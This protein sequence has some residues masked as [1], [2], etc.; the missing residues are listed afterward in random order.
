MR[1]RSIV[2]FIALTSI[3]ATAVQLPESGNTIGFEV[4]SVKPNDSGLPAMNLGRP[5]KGRTYTA[6]N[7]AL[8]NV[9]ALAYGFPV[10]RVL[11][12]PSWVGTASTDLRF[13]GGDRFDIAATLPQGV[14]V[15]Q[16]PSMLRALL[17]DRFRL[18][19]HTEVRQTPL[20]ALVVVRNDGRLGPQLRKAS[21]D[22]EDAQAA[23]TIITTAKAGERSLCESEVGSAILGRGQR[24]SSLGRM[25]S[26]FADR[27]V[28]D[29][30]GLAGGFDFE[31]RFPEL[32]TAP[33]ATG[34]RA[35]PVNGIFTALQEQ[36]GLK[37]ESTRGN[38]ELVVI[39]SVQHPTEN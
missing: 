2:V 21:I 6:T 8:R 37:L 9:I 34:P 23:G 4:A 31:L 30:T 5:F 26:M 36:L 3:R 38:I 7:A 28:V 10:E 39:D 24:M 35:D 29:R 13:V 27:P 15:E 16:I 18:I 19:V 17:A 22:C 14:G 32:T 33:D 20:Y 25:L 1:V 11:G 12:G